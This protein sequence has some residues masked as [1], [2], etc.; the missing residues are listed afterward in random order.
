[1]QDIQIKVLV[2][3]VDGVLLDSKGVKR[4]SWR[5][6][7]ADR[8]REDDKLLQ[9]KVDARVGDRYAIIR[10]TLWELGESA[11]LDKKIARYAARYDELVREGIRERGVFPGVLEMLAR[12][13]RRYPLYV[14]SFTPDK[15]L[16]ATLEL[17]DLAKHFRGIYGSSR[18]K[19]LNLKDIG[20]REGMWSGHLLMIGDEPGDDEA[21]SAV[22]C[23][24][25]GIADKVNGWRAGAILP[26]PVVAA[27]VELEALLG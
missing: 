14:N 12:L 8:S 6:V 22:G 20:V 2:F 9:A 1:M 26:F 23:R 25:L 10:Q 21:A 19:V 5:G 17:F 11:D 24:F 4:E 3:D 13:I 7:F 18:S 15:A 27:T 16:R